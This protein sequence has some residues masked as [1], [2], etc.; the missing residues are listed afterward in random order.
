[1]K[2]VALL[3]F[4]Y[5][6]VGEV[7]EVE[8]P[9]AKKESPKY[10][11]IGGTAEYE[12][13]Q[14]EPATFAFLEVIKVRL[15]GAIFV[16][17][18]PLQKYFGGENVEGIK[19]NE[20]TPLFVD[21]TPTKGKDGKFNG[22]VKDYFAAYAIPAA[23]ADNPPTPVVAP[24]GFNNIT[25][26]KEPKFYFYVKKFAGYAYEK[27]ILIHASAL[28]EALEADGIE[29]KCGENCSWVF[30]QY[31]GGFLESR[32]EVGWYTTAKPEKRLW[33]VPYEEEATQAI[34]TS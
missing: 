14:Y 15:D 11:I 27:A 22:T 18:K 30:A 19:L 33:T 17:T 3:F 29:L 21:F 13:R 23:D 8:R 10:K 5:Y 4:V 1:M 34:L 7:V 20:T 9:A 32:N 12:I 6:A 25:I 28:L 26:D 31:D 24:L 16:A 2:F